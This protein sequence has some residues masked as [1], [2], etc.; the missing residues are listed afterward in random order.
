M[1]RNAFTV[2]SPVCPALHLTPVEDRLQYQSTLTHLNVWASLVLWMIESF[3]V[4]DA[5]KTTFIFNCISFVMIVYGKKHFVAV[6]VTSLA[7]PTVATASETS[8]VPQGMML[9]LNALM[10][11]EYLSKPL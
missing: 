8:I 6:C 10:I 7:I 2:S 3:C 4:C 11:R 9:H 1:I 5:Q